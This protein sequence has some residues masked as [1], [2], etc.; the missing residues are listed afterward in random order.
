MKQTNARTEFH[1]ALGGKS[2]RLS[3][4]VDEATKD[5][6][7][8]A[9]TLEGLSITSFVLRQATQ[10]ARAVISGHERLI[11]SN[12]DRDTFFALLDNPPSPTDALRRAAR[13]HKQLIHD[14]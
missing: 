11:L 14:A 8:Q 5:I 2:K 7:E 1:G 6:L 13:R 10:G 3:I 9:A 12:R 4:R